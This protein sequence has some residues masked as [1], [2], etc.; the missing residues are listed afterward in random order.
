MNIV[1][2]VYQDA[3]L[4]QDTQ[5]QRGTDD[6]SISIRRGTPMQHKLFK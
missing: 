2:N 5:D 3:T 1:F 4:K 6:M